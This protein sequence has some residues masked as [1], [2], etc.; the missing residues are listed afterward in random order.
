MSQCTACRLFRVVGPPE[1]LTALLDRQR[2]ALVEHG[3]Q[4]LAGYDQIVTSR[5]HGA[6]LGLLLGKRVGLLGSLTGKS[7]AF[8]FVELSTEEEAQ[9]AMDA[10]NGT[11]LEG[12]TITVNEAR[13]REN[14]PNRDRGGRR[15]RW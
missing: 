6:L 5:L 7:R 4:L 9:N 1:S 3:I 12:R 15:N 14:R 2:V 11:E 8:G 10:L 13:Q